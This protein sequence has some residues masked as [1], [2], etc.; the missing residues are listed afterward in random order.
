VAGVAGVQIFQL[1]RSGLALGLC[2]ALVSEETCGWL[3]IIRV[4]L[5]HW[6]LYLC[7]V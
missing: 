3:H 7:E 6:C 4:L 1:R 2:S 5:L